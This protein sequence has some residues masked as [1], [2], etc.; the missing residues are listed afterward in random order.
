MHKKDL[1]KFKLNYTIEGCK[2]QINELKR[3]IVFKYKHSTRK[4]DRKY[5]NIIPYSK[6]YKSLDRHK[7]REIFLNTLRDEDFPHAIWRMTGMSN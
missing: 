1:L 5:A 2:N 6:E 7:K 4:I 3:K